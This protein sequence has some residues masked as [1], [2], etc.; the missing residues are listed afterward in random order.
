[1]R[2][3]END[4]VLFEDGVALTFRSKQ[5]GDARPVG[6]FKLF[7]GRLAIDVVSTA[8]D[9][10]DDFI[11]PWEM[12]IAAYLGDDR[13]VL[14]V[15][16]LTQGEPLET[17]GLEFTFL[18]EKQFTR[19]S[20]VNNPGVKFLWWATALIVLGIGI[21]FYFP[22][23][24]LW[25]FCSQSASESTMAI[26]G[27]APRLSGFDQEFQRLVKTL[28]QGLGTESYHDLPAQSIPGNDSQRSL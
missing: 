14:F 12:M 27:A 2:D 13:S 24:R 25:L 4:K 20:V 7:D 17:A 1:V 18:R 28:E 15:E 5:Y 19:L 21:V 11:Q 16:K 10:I 9:A 8:V 6:F 26:A 3:T 22:N 23:R